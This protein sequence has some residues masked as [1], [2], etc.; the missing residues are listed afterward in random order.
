MELP[1]DKIIIGLTGGIG[2]GKST[3]VDV[4]KNKFSDKYFFLCADELCHE[5][6][7]DYA[8]ELN[9]NFIKH[10]NESFINEEGVINR[11]DIAN[12]IFANEN[13]LSELSFLSAVLNPYIFKKAQERIATASQKFIIFDIPLLFESNLETYFEAVIGVWC[14][15]EKQNQRLLKRGYSKT[16]VEFRKKAQ[17]S[18]DIKLELADYAIINNGSLNELVEQ[19]KIIDKKLRVKYDRKKTK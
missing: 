14:S 4:F 9:K 18:A 16:E 3:V 12:K 11:K 13:Y 8:T 17:L 5:V 7:Y 1:S 10:W 2:C 6:Y 19:C 15:K